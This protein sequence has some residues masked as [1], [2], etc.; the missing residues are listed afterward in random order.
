MAQGKKKGVFRM[1][2][3]AHF[4][5]YAAAVLA[6]LWLSGV[7]DKNPAFYLAL[8]AI[9]FTSHWL[10]DATHIVERWMRFYRQSNLEVVR[11][12][13]DQTLH[14]LVLAALAVLV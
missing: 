8:G 5:T 4:A 13:V 1:A 6:A 14:L 11:L 9:I 12:M 2:G 3:L 10:I 7:R